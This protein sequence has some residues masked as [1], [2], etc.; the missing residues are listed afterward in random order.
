MPNDMSTAPRDGT[1]IVL[2]T[3]RLPSRGGMDQVSILGFYG[4]KPD[5]SSGWLAVDSRHDPINEEE[6]IG[7]TP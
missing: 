6:I 1:H 7:W 5:G 2:H 4:R 3:K